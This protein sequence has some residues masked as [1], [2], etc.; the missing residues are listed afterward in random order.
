MSLVVWLRPG[1]GNHHTTSDM[2]DDGGMVVEDDSVLTRPAP[3]PDAV[4]RWGPGP[5]DVAD[6]QLGGDDRPL[7]VVVHGGFWRPAYDRRHLRPMIHALAAA[8][9]TA[10]APEYRRIP[11]DPDAAVE[12]VRVALR[13]LPV[14][15]RGRHD[16]R[17]VVLG[18]SAG[19]HLALWAASAAPAA[20]LHA[21]LALAPVA[22]LAAADRERLGGGAV[23]AFLGGAAPTR[24]DL[25]PTRRVSATT[26][27]TLLHGLE[28][29]TVPPAQS[30]A[31]VAAHP[32]A[33]LVELPGAGHFD[34]IDPL[35]AA[36]PRVVAAL[37]DLVG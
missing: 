20:G 36:W 22:D 6:V 2:R 35:S 12:D 11:G 29:T 7:V 31:Y 4:V 10:V 34:V 25:D 24:P 16:G 13:V 15:L 28:D 8:G 3:E 17:V 27:V 26:P 32:D 33:L 19:G 18:H 37:V 1:P 30:A 21:T 9:F 14:D 23:S 5:D